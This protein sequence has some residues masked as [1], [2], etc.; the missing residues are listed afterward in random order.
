M[1]NRDYFKDQVEWDGSQ[2]YAPEFRHMP[3]LD[4]F[5]AAPGVVLRPQWGENLMASY[6]TFAPEAEAPLHQHGQ[7]QFSVVLSGSL[8]FTVGNQSQWMS[9]GDVVTI[10]AG[11]PHAAVAGKEGAVAID[12]FTPPRD[13]F[14]EL[15][16]A[17]KG[18][19]S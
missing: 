11:V 7:E 8:Y 17:Q 12:M 6:V 5:E 14:R 1:I 3:D 4:G 9:P 15:I 18:R 19:S 16:D 2:A 10:P 13:G